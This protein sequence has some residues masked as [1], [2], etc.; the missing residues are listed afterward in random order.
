MKLKKALSIFAPFAVYAFTG[1]N[2]FWVMVLIG[3]YNM[4]AARIV[5]LLIYT[6]LAVIAARRMD[7]TFGLIG[8]G[9]Y[10][11]MLIA[12]PL[13]SFNGA[14]F[15]ESSAAIYGNLF[16]FSL[17]DFKPNILRYVVSVVI[18]LIPLAV[19][20][21]L[22]KNSGNVNEIQ[23]E[24]NEKHQKF[25][26]YAFSILMPLVMLY[27]TMA[28]YIFIGILTE[29]VIEIGLDTVIWIVVGVYIVAS[30]VIGC[31]M[32][33]KPGLIGL[34]VYLVPLLAGAF[35]FKEGTY[36]FMLNPFVQFFAGVEPDALRGILSILLAV[37]PFAV[38]IIIRKFAIKK[39]EK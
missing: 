1:I 23:P 26:K 10:S 21:L 24:V 20:L 34:A 11:V 14:E 31:F 4:T 5:L 17:F 16:Y 15:G 12:C 36:V 13:F 18:A 25:K 29:G 37:A 6:A 19:G 28:I 27:A 33:V 9:L 22:Q 35:A 39:S 38:G 2:I 30:A 32:D 7:K 8:A 3:N